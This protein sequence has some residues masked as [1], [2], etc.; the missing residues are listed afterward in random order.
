MNN[1]NGTEANSMA[2]SSVGG[3]TAQSVQP[4]G[5]IMEEG[6]PQKTEMEKNRLKLKWNDSPL[7]MQ[8]RI[9]KFFGKSGTSVV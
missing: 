7:L 3:I 2:A 6:S 8:G 5:E 1:W 4:Q 9:T